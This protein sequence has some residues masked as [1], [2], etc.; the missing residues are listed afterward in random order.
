MLT[1]AEAISI[2]KQ[3]AAAHSLEW[4]EPARAQIQN[5]YQANDKVV[6]SPAWIVTT[7]ASHQGGNFIAT[8][9]AHTGEVV[10]TIWRCET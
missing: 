5:S 9:E 1:E 7:N 10:W 8:V 3:H 4:K 2:A 6:Q